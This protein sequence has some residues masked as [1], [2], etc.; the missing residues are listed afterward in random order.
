MPVILIFFNTTNLYSR[1]AKHTQS[2][3]QPEGG[4][5]AIASPKFSLKYLFVRCSNK[6]HHFAHPPENNTWLLPC[7]HPN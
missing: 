4:N 2:G 5:R 3:P 7:T 6:L 1:C